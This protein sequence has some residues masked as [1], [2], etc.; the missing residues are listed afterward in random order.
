MRQTKNSSDFLREKN[1]V[2]IKLKFSNKLISKAGFR[3]FRMAEFCYFRVFISKRQVKTIDHQVIN[4]K[5]IWLILNYS[6]R[7]IVS[8]ILIFR[9]L[10]RISKNSQRHWKVEC[11]LSL[12]W[13]IKKCFS[14]KFKM[15]KR[16][17]TYLR[18]YSEMLTLFSK[19][20]FHK[21]IVYGKKFLV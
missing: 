21:H 7:H 6:D 19:T 2:F 3:I 10:V 16:D 14:I 18:K 15:K 20:Q 8:T 13:E 4:F 17:K 11:F 12:I 9:N 1:D 5:Q